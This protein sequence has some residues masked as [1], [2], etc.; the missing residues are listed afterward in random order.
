M[1][2][3]GLGLC[4]WMLNCVVFFGCVVWLPASRE[5]RL[6]RPVSDSVVASKVWGCVG[7]C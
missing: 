7:G 4:G 6:G 5:V 1:D 2:V 3:K